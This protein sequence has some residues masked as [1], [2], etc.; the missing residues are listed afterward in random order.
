MAKSAHRVD[1][2]FDHASSDTA[3]APTHSPLLLAIE[4]QAENRPPAAAESSQQPIIDPDVYRKGNGSG[5]S[6]ESG[7]LWAAV[8]EHLNGHLRVEG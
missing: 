8:A 5:R 6:R 2:E 4:L 7:A 1:R 3:L